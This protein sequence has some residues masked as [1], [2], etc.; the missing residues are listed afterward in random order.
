MGT[1]LSSQ[2]FPKSRSLLCKQILFP[3]FE[4]VKIDIAQMPGRVFRQ[5]IILI[6]I[7]AASIYQMPTNM[8]HTFPSS[9]SGAKNNETRLS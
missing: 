2:N 6:I 1:L 9:E 5:M 7:H 4:I 3:L 8:P